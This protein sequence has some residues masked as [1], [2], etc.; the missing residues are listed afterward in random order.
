MRRRSAGR[1]P[2]DS[3][4]HPRPRL[5]DDALTVVVPDELPQLSPPAARALLRLLR[6]AHRDASARSREA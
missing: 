6:N 5:R 4:P 2:C 3:R 1:G